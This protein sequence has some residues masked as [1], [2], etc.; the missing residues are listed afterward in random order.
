MWDLEWDVLGNETDD[1]AKAIR[2]C[3][4]KT[5]GDTPGNLSECDNILS[6]YPRYTYTN[7]IQKDQLPSLAI[8]LNESNIILPQMCQSSQ[9]SITEIESINIKGNDLVINYKKNNPNPPTPI[10]SGEF[11]PDVII[12]AK[13]KDGENACC[14][15]KGCYCN[16]DQCP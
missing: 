2:D 6:K 12:G 4:K 8:N 15:T 13:C 5:H 16:K 10:C 11:C 7:N 3:C 9:P 14:N 1:T